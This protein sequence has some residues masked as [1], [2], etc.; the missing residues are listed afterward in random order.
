[1]PIVPSPAIASNLLA[2]SSN[3]LK[4]AKN[5]HFLGLQKLKYLGTPVMNLDEVF[6]L[7]LDKICASFLVIKISFYD[8]RMMFFQ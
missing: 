1:M 2:F 4:I 6:F 5:H 3:F 8:R 7:Y